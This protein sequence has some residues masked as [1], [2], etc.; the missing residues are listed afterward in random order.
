[1]YAWRF[2]EVLPHSDL[3]VLRGIEGARLKRLYQTLADK[4]GVAWNGRTYDRMAPEEADH[5]NQAINHVAT[6][7]YAAASIAVNAVGAVPQLGFI[8]EASGDAFCLDI[9][10]LFRVDETIP[11][12][13]QVIRQWNKDGRDPLERASRRAAGRRFRD[14]KVIERMIER[15]KELFDVSD[16]SRNPE[17]GA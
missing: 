7:M 11:I 9:A 15:I 8:H 1:M 5:V 4:Y 14:G 10:D 2:G 6:A 16:G 12:A 13:F 3:D 17:R